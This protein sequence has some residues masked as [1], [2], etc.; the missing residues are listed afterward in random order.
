[1][2]KSIRVLYV[3]DELALLELGKLFLKESGEFS[4]TTIA[5]APAAIELLNKEKFDAIISD[6]QMPGM[7]GIQFL[8][9]VRLHFGTIPFIL[10][11][12]KG[13]EEVIIQAISNGADFYLQKGG[14]PESQF[15]ELSHVV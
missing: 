1:M 5:S 2:T 15:A 8:V 11:T 6:Y 12:G 10:L 7:D 3:D 9:E 13:R 4:V 14:E